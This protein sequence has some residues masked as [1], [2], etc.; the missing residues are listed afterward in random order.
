MRWSYVAPGLLALLLAYIGIR[1]LPLLP[2]P[3]AVIGIVVLIAQFAVIV[4]VMSPGRRRRTH[5][6]ALTWAGLTALG[7]FSSL[8]VL[9]LLRDVA[10]VLLGLWS[11][12]LND[13]TPWARFGRVTAWGV[14]L[15]AIAASLL[16]FIGARRVPQVREVEV[17]IGDLPRSLHGFSIVQISD[18]HVGPTI[19]GGF[20]RKVVERANSLQPDLTVVTGDMVDGSV[21]ALAEHTEP[22]GRLRSRHGVFAVTGNHEYYSGAHPWI[23]EFER[24][25]LEVLMNE[26]RLLRHGDASLLLAGVPDFSAHHFDER[27]RSDP[28]RAAEGAPAEA[29][30]RVLL[31]HQPRTALMAEAAGFDLQLSGHTHGGQFLPWKWFVPLQQPYTAGLHRLGGLWVYVSRGTG[32]WGPPK[33]LGAP[34]EITLLRLV[35]G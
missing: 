30:P 11:W 29:R 27:H 19:R 5:G 12:A 6:A 33:R 28:V 3:A 35:P 25:G 23:A 22:L 1:L 7:L 4:A 17:P 34:S 13:P 26:H 18:L 15:L 9:T 2:A 21:P 20:V 8:F 24:L 31:A 32:Y 14:P 10:W 16:G